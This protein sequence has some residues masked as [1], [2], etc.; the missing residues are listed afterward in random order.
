MAGGEA[1]WSGEYM[2]K[3]IMNW[4]WRL[5]WNERGDIGGGK[6]KRREVTQQTQAQQ[7]Q[8]QQTQQTQVAPVSA[9]EQQALAAAHQSELFRMFLAQREAQQRFTENPLETTYGQ[10]GMQALN[11]QFRDEADLRGLYGA[12]ASPIQNARGLAQ[13]QYIANLQQM[14][15]QKRMGILGQLGPSPGA[16]GMLGLQ[17]QG[18]IAGSPTVTSGGG[19]GFTTLGGTTNA[20][21]SGNQ[22]GFNMGNFGNML[23]GLGNL[24]G[25]YRGPA[26]TTPTTT[27]PSVPSGGY[28]GGYNYGNFG[29]GYTGG[30]V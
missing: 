9:Q 24:Y 15:F 20:T 16:L 3:N 28:G 14:D 1:D 23:L 7:Q 2:D 27:T 21:M 25:A 6:S 13:A 18:R 30:L 12:T 19:T 10:Q 11:Q 8:F 29:S 26:G 4:N 5:Y 22:Q 17:Q